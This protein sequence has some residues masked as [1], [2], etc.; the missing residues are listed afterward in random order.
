[1]P[2]SRRRSAARAVTNTG[3]IDAG[4]QQHQP[5]DTHQHHAEPGNRPAQRFADQAGRGKMEPRLTI[6]H[7]GIGLGE[8]PRDPVR[9]ASAWARVTPG[10]RRPTA[11]MFDA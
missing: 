6:E 7:V 1:M 5:A 3:Q 4:E 11:Q 9:S 2:I 10:R 8:L